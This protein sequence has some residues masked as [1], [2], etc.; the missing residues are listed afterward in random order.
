VR[1][2]RQDTVT[3]RDEYKKQGI[4]ETH[5]P[6]IMDCRKQSQMSRIE[7]FLIDSSING[8]DCQVIY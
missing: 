4:F 7:S 1:D 2:V 3:K 6:A 5:Q 8:T